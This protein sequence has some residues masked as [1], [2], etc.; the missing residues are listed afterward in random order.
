MKA[1]F[2]SI[3]LAVSLAAVAQQPPQPPP[4]EKVSPKQP[5]TSTAALLAWERQ[6]NYQLTANALT[7]DFQ[8]KM[9][10]LQAKSQATLEVMND[11]MKE[12]RKANGWDDS[13]LYD[14]EKDEWHRVKKDEAKKPEPKK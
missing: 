10:D 13:Y 12:T 6:K 7:A 8:G 4:S 2:G 11:F 9:R 5:Y 1:I 3:I 14:P